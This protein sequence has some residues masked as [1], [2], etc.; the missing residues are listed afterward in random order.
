MDVQS[1]EEL[2][3]REEVRDESV[4]CSLVVWISELHT[5]LAV[6]LSDDCSVVSHD[7]LAG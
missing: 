7:F 4:S 3:R 2:I 5:V 1:L 6:D